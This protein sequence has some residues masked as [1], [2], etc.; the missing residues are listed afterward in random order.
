[1]LKKDLID[2][3]TEKMDGYLKKDIGQ[4]VDILLETI[5]A[6]LIEE[7]RVEIRGFGSFSVRMRKA[8][9]TKNP[10]TGEVMNI[11]KRKTLHF[12]MSKSLKEPLAG[13]K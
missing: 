3:V 11:P 4:A 1:M 10:K 2:T 8:R 6:A 7:R 9:S 13:K 5:V 12:T